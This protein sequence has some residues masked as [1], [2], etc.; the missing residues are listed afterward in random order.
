MNK[1]VQHAYRGGK[2]RAIKQWCKKYNGKKP[3]K[4]FTQKL[5]FAIQGYD[6]GPFMQ[7][8]VPSPVI[9]RIGPPR[10][11]RE[12][13][14][15]APLE[16]RTRLVKDVC[17]VGDWETGD[18]EW[19][20]ATVEELRILDTT[21]R[22]Q[23]QAG[24][25]HNLVWDH[26]ADT[27]GQIDPNLPFDPNVPAKNIIAKLEE[28]IE[29]NGTLWA[30]V[31]VNEAEAAQL[32]KS[33]MQVSVRIVR[34]WKDGTGTLWPLCLLHVAV[35]DH[36]VIPGQGPFI[37]LSIDRYRRLYDPSHQKRKVIDMAITLQP[38]VEAI[39]ALL[40]NGLTLPESITDD[41]FDE[42]L[43]MVMGMVNAQPGE[44]TP[45][46]DEPTGDLP[47]DLSK[48]AEAELAKSPVL[49]SLAKGQQQLTK[50]VA[51][52]SVRVNSIVANEGSKSKAA[53]QAKVLELAAKGDITAAIAESLKATGP[54]A[55][56]D[57]S[58]LKPYE[59]MRMVD[60]SKKGQRFA[61]GNPPALPDDNAALTDAEE[62][63]AGALLGLKSKK[64]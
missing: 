8:P 43:A 27:G 45:P 7:C 55:N 39:N 60:M 29:H 51:D 24:V 1:A 25:F 19:W 59:G 56:Y 17:R 11:T 21:F 34:N 20:H 58:I 50:L 42:V 38:T 30:V 46:P 33:A 16:Q 35:V 36:A 57:L 44:E 4:A 26:R 64:K 53:Y 5:D 40:P 3:P 2:R 15:E 52:L 23:F 18:N 10:W 49:L 47:A 22:N 41:N 48:A 6:V 12:Q 13:Q 54:A 28:L 31:Y 61:T 14:C 32:R 9:E 62:D 37:D 63:E